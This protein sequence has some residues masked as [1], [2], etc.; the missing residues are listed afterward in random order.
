M[1][2]SIKSKS[3]IVFNLTTHRTRLSDS[4]IFVTDT[5]GMFR[6]DCVECTTSLG[7]DTVGDLDT[8]TIIST[9]DV[10]IIENFADINSDAVPP[11][12]LSES[13]TGYHGVTIDTDSVPI[14]GTVIISDTD[15]IYYSTDSVTEIADTENT[16]DDGPNLTN[17]DA[18]AIFIDE[19]TQY[20]LSFATKQVC[21][22]TTAPMKDPHIWQECWEP[23]Q[24]IELSLMAENNVHDWSSI[25]KADDNLITG[26]MLHSTKHTADRSIE[27][28][29]CCHRFHTNRRHHL[30]CKYHICTNTF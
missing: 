14:N 23:V 13:E 1:G 6:K 16:T 20:I 5:N 17:T 11:E 27:K 12:V 19:D 18:H 25:T 26:K 30:R 10:Q 15:S 3:F 29:N 7:D 2:N 8:E 22:S 4:V 24:N 28:R 21:N 9:P